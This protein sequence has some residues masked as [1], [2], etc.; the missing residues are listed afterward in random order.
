MIAC[1]ASTCRH[2]IAR[3]ISLGEHGARHQCADCNIR[4]G[5]RVEDPGERS[6]L[7][8]DDQDGDPCGVF[9]NGMGHGYVEQPVAAGERPGPTM[10]RS[11]RHGSGS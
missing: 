2:S 7:E 6:A 9:G 3:P 1:R 8:R 11:V 4:H 5:R 10:V